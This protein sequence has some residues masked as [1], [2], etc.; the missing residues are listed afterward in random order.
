M[1]SLAR[2]AGTPSLIPDARK[3]L[4]KQTCERPHKARRLTQRNL[5]KVTQ[6]RTFAICRDGPI[7]VI[8][9]NLLPSGE[10]VARSQK[11]KFGTPLL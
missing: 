8:G 2:A 4:R 7:V 1:T 3:L 10:N 11:R 9:S 5:P 6:E